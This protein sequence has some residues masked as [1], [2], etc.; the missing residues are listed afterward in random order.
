MPKKVSILDVGWGD[1]TSDPNSGSG[2]DAG[3]V[4]GA[5]HINTDEYETPKVYVEGKA[6]DYKTEWRLNSDKELI[7]LCEKKG[8]NKDDC[9]LITGYEP[10]ATTRMGVILKYLGVNNVHVMSCAMNGWNANSYGFEKGINKPEKTDLG[11]TTPQNPDV[12]DTIEEVK[13]EIKDTDNYVVIDTRTE[14]EWNGTD[15][16]YGY[17]DLKGRIPGTVFSPCSIGFSS[18]V[19]YYRNADMSMRSADALEA[20][21]KSQGIDSNKHLVY[22]CGSGWRVSETCWASWIM[23]KKASIYSDGWIGWS[24]E[25]NPY[26][27]DGKTFE[28]DKTNGKE[29]NISALKS[30]KPAKVKATAGNKKIT[31]KWTSNTD[32]TKYV[33][34]KSAKK[35]SGFKAVTS[36]AKKTVTVKNLKNGKKYY[37]KVVGYKNL[38]GSKI[39]T[40]KSNVIAATA[41]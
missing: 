24:N 37:Y 39:Y 16:G 26:L 23:G 20:M 3:H 19:Y 5:V 8:I 34:Y 4:P 11:I 2:Y 9:V 18:S 36:T 38:N 12:I 6:D 10:M 1:E 41:K 29:I 21:W 30:A 31:L 25:G 35:T 40:K 32:V 7:E 27:R 17:H 14:G 15:S 13:G 22:F 33:V 28:M